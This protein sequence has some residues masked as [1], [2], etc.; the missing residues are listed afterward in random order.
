MNDF[1]AGS[2]KQ[3]MTQFLSLFSFIYPQGN[4]EIENVKN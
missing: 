2:G 4:I 3:S 1:A